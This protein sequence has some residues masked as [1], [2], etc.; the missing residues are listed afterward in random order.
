[1]EIVKIDSLQPGLLFYGLN[2][3]SEHFMEE[4]FRQLVVRHFHSSEDIGDSSVVP[5]HRVATRLSTTGDEGIARIS[6]GTFA[7]GDVAA[8]FAFCIYTALV[9]A[10]INTLVIAAGT[11]IW[12]VFVYLTLTLH[13]VMAVRRCIQ[14]KEYWNENE[15]RDLISFVR[16][17]LATA[18]NYPLTIG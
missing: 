3:L 11:M 7:Y 12:T 4:T 2:P 17:S 8:R 6:V 9:L 15:E 5:S 1:M 10:R 13:D 14:I 16:R 18:F